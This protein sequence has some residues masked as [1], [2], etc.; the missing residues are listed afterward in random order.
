VQSANGGSTA[1]RPEA[2]DTIT[3]TYTEP[4]DPDSVLSGW[5]GSPTSVVV[6][7]TNGLL[8]VNDTLRVFD[9]TDTTPVSLGQVDLGRND[10]VGGALGGEVLRF[11]ATGTPS[12]MSRSGNSIAI[13]FGTASGAGTATTAASAGAMS[14]PPSLLATDR[15]GNGA[16]VVPASESG[17]ADREF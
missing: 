2:G 5:D 15:A 17:A 4:L 13:A 10:Y 3:F 8:V 12:T 11:G 9:P 1:W 14:W 16:S 6:R 7:M